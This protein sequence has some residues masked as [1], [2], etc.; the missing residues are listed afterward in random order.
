MAVQPCLDGGLPEWSGGR[1]GGALGVHTLGS[2]MTTQ[3]YLFDR[4]PRATVPASGGSPLHW[5]YVKTLYLVTPVEAGKPGSPPRPP[6]A[7]F[8]EVI[9]HLPTHPFHLKSARQVKFT[10]TT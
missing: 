10:P 4:H 7:P 1:F 2:V 6:M 8:T 9:Y 5:W 3:R